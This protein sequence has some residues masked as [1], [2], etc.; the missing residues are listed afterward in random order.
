MVTDDRDSNDAPRAQDAAQNAAQEPAGGT[1]HDA[2]QHPID[3]TLDV[4]EARALA[5]RMRRL[6]GSIARQ[7]AQF[8]ELL[9]EIDRTEAWAHW[10]GIRTLVQW[11]SFV[12][13]MDAHTAREH[14]R[15]MRGLRAMPKVARLLASGR[16]SFSKAR[17]ITRLAGRIDDEEAAGITRRATAS[18]ISAMVAAYRRLDP[19]DTDELLDS[20]VGRLPQDTT[21]IRVSGS[22][23]EAA[24]GPED[25]A[26]SQP[27]PAASADQADAGQSQA[28]V[29]DAGQSET[30]VVTTRLPVRL[31]QD[32]LHL[33]TQQFGRA[34]II[35]D[36]PEADALELLAALDAIR[37]ALRAD[38]EQGPAHHDSANRVDALLELVRMHRD[39]TALGSPATSSRATLVVRVSPEALDAGSG[40]TR[41]GDR[42]AEDGLGDATALSPSPRAERCH[43]ADRGPSTAAS[44]ARLACGGTLV[45]A[46]IDDSGDVLALGRS[47]RLA[48][49]RQRLA[50]SA[51]D[52]HC[53]FPTCARRTGLEAH[54]IRMWSEGG[55]TDLDNMLLLCRSHHIAVHEHGLRITRTEDPVF[56]GALRAGT[57]FAFHTQEGIRIR[58]GDAADLEV[59]DP[60][61]STPSAGSARDADGVVTRPLV[62]G[63]P[64]AH[65][66]PHEPEIVT[67]GGGWGFTLDAGVAW[68]FDAEATLREH[69]LREHSLREHSLGEQGVQE[70]RCQEGVHQEG[71]RPEEHRQE[72]THREDLPS[73]A[74]QTRT[75]PTPAQ[76]QDPEGGWRINP[77]NDWWM[78]PE[79]PFEG[80][81][82]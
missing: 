33:S 19:A 8:L 44:A 54:H 60:G 27:V 34:R 61:V 45:G 13:E 15:V 64:H 51:R 71:A 1:P 12:C 78:D 22:P 36:L 7:Q 57:G 48:S 25:R 11:V 39:G 59:P 30:A 37:D 9:D 5:D 73:R 55:P 77:S 16:I 17:E 65:L 72:A 50:L 43:T 2:P 29:A 42:G 80:D 20:L 47:R 4:R 82:G 79:S 10:I 75:D 21:E 63:I 74:D 35:L 41:D 76:G 81:R 69:R 24:A 23:A 32:S 53:Q 68:L 6:A 66:G 3:D 14:I 40:A 28:D 46:L 49:S 18:Q 70:E 56:S 31:E 67:E 52:L 38:E 26:G 62:L 58:P